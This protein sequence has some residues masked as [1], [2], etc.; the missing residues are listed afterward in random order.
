MPFLGGAMWLVQYNDIVFFLRRPM[1]G[2][3][4]PSV[5]FLTLWYTAPIFT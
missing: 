1:L 5:Y 2:A 4:G 3:A